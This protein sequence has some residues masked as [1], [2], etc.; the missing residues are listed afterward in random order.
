MIRACGHC[1]YA[2]MALLCLAAGPSTRPDD[3]PVAALLND[4]GSSNP[5][6]RQLAQESLARRGDEARDALLAARK[7]A[8]PETLARIGQLLKNLPRFRADDPPAVRDLLNRFNGFDFS[9]QKEALKQLADLPGSTGIDVLFRLLDEEQSESLR[10]AIAGQLSALKTPAAAERLRGLDIEGRSAADLVAIGWAWEKQDPAKATGVFVKA[11]EAEQAHRTNDSGQMTKVFSWLVQT[12]QAKKDYN[13]TAQWLRR[14]LERD[15][16]DEA[17]GV[18][19]ELLKLQGNFGPLNGLTRDLQNFGTPLGEPLKMY[20]LARLATRTGQSALAETF[21]LAAMASPENTVAR[22][23]VAATLVQVGWIEPAEAE[24]EQVLRETVDAPGPLTS[25]AHLLFGSILLQKQDYF[26]SGEQLRMALEKRDESTQ[27]N[28]TDAFGRSTVW[29]DRE[30]WTEVNWRYYLAAKKS[31]DVIEVD[32]CLK[33]IIRL[34]SAESNLA[35]DL[36]PALKEN[37]HPR[38]AETIFRRVYESIAP[39]VNENPENAE[40]QNNLAWLCARCDQRLPEALDRAN[41]AVETSPDNPAYI[42]TLAEVHFRLGH[43]IKAARLERRA[44]ELRPDDTFM[45]EQLKRFEI[46]GK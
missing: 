39:M 29:T 18:A 26:R 13:L 25:N 45:L 38:E 15:G 19:M 35:V 20:A 3:R 11:I 5:A 6:V 32:R 7:D 10:W 41:R 28:R 12:A 2:L 14:H 44:L 23:E 17:P 42:D 21:S 33:E 43:T 8:G 22:S 46:A 27:I 36:V 16:A 34:D 24:L 37:N 40:F 9:Q 31:G 4:L 1:T 30:A